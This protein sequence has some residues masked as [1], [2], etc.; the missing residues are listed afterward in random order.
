MIEPWLQQKVAFG[1]I[2]AMLLTS[3]LGWL[4]WRN[5]KISSAQADSVAHTYTVVNQLERTLEHVVDVETGS[6]GFAATGQS[7]FLDPSDSAQTLLVQDLASLKQ[8]T[9]GDYKQMTWLAPLTNDIDSSVSLAQKMVDQ[10][11]Q[12]ETVPLGTQFEQGK[13]LVDSVRKTIRAQQTQRSLELT[14]QIQ[15]TARKRR[16]ADVVM[17]TST[18]VELSLLVLAWMAVNRALLVSARARAQVE[19]S[20]VEL[21]QRVAERTEQ[22]SAK[23]QLLAKSS[24]ALRAESRTLQ[25]VLDNMEE[26]LAAADAEGQFTLWNHAAETILGTPARNELVPANWS[27]GYGLYLSDGETLCPTEKLPLVRAMRGDAC[28]A[29]MFV[30]NP[31]CPQGV[32]IEVSARPLKDEDGKAQGGLATFRDISRRKHDEDQIRILN[33]DLEQKVE[34]RTAQLEAANKE[35]EAFTYSV[36]HDLRAPLRHI[37]GFSRILIEEFAASVP[38]E[39]SRY[40]ERIAD[41]ARKMGVLLDELLAL[42]GVGRHALSAESANL[43]LLVEDVVSMLAPETDGRL[44]EWQIAD[45]GSVNCDL[46]LLRQVFQNLIANALKFTRPRATA[47]IEIGCME[48]HGEFTFFVRDNGVGFD[49]KYA[50]KLFGVFQRLHKLEDFEGTGI[51][52]ATVRRIIQKHAGRTWAEAELG[53]GATFYFTINLP[54]E[55]EVKTN[56]VPAGVQS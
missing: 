22:L 31:G 13:R 19:N 6:R 3:S 28:D 54:V 45:L 26:G 52:L 55:V 46:A 29:E 20:N 42:A 40:L 16:Q 27:E 50:D 21:E 23:A 18:L 44:V 37:S 8:S 49:M 12:G 4:S 39:A 9:A 41:G 24:D 48:D 36:S 32:W 53:K 14:R 56:A 47:I 7:Q 5:K 51:G 33:D 2:G 34:Q 30:R 11:R 17:L 10:R 43:N 25:S 1:F 35:L 38:A 15:T